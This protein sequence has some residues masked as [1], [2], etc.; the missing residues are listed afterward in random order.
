MPELLTSAST[1]SPNCRGSR[2]SIAQTMSE[3]ITTKK[4][5]SC[6]R[7]LWKGQMYGRKTLFS[8]AVNLTGSQN[9]YQ[10]AFGI[11]P[12]R[13]VLLDNLAEST[14]RGLT[15]FSTQVSSSRGCENLC[16][17]HC[18]VNTCTGSCVC[19]LIIGIH[20]RILPIKKWLTF[21]VP[22][23]IQLTFGKQEQ[24]SRQA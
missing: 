5:L 7:R 21:F 13:L 19:W 2:T 3:K 18:S 22:Y 23:A 24:N 4:S 17:R 9:D 15:Y 10:K 11:L 8:S 20:I 12:P 14:Y 16:L 1:T 6:K